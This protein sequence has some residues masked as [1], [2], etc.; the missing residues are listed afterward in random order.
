MAKK[1]KSARQQAAERKADPTAP[2]TPLQ[3]AQWALESGDVARAR[4][5]ALEAARSG[6]EAERPEAARMLERLKPDPRALLTVAMVLLMIVVAAW[7]ALL[8]AR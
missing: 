5:L 6:P 8:R 7:A 4:A 2:S 3:K 1:S